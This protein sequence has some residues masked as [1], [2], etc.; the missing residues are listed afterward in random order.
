MP[1][2][3][4]IWRGQLGVYVGLLAVLYI[5]P[6]A[7]GL[8]Q[9]SAPAASITYT[10]ADVTAAYLLNFIRFTNWPDSQRS[11]ENQAYVIG[12]SGNPAVQDAL[13]R[14]VDGVRVHERPLRVVRLKSPGD[15]SAC[16]LVY[17]EPVLPNQGVRLA[18]A[19]AAI[20]GKPI[21]SVSPAPD[22]L[23]RGGIVQ[24]FPV[25]GRLRFS[26]AA[27]SAQKGGLMLHSRLLALALPLPPEV[28]P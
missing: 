8:A 24:L 4:S 16:D 28:T 13:I 23:R 27:D 17:L 22:F 18:E 6:P 19:L 7:I 10:T 5:A 9:D 3:V 15:I 25:A 11:T 20:E 14:L 26:I 12:I 21:L 2:I 1:R